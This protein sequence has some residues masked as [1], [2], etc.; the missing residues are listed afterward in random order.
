MDF[1]VVG[2]GVGA[3]LALIGFAL[4]EAST[5]HK[6]ASRRWTPLWRDLGLS[7]MLS[8]V[9][10]WVVTGVALTAGSADDEGTMVLMAAGFIALVGLLGRAAIVART[11]PDVP[12]QTAPPVRQPRR[13]M[14]RPATADLASSH[15]LAVRE[16]L[17]A[18]PTV[19][20]RDLL[21][22]AA[23]AAVAEDEVIVDTS[24]FQRDAVVEASEPEE[25]MPE[26]VSADDEPPAAQAGADATEPAAIE[27]LEQLEQSD[28]ERDAAPEGPDGVDEVVAVQ[29]GPLP[30][31][32]VEPASEAESEIES[33]DLSE[34]RAVEDEADLEPVHADP[35]VD[36]SAATSDEAI[37]PGD[38]DPPEPETLAAEALPEPVP[39]E[40]PEASVQEL[41]P[42]DD[43]REEPAADPEVKEADGASNDGEESPAW[44]TS[45]L[46]ADLADAD[47]G[48]LDE[49]FRSPILADIDRSTEG[50]DDNE[51]GYLEALFGPPRD[52]ESWQPSELDEEV[53]HELNGQRRF[54]RRGRDG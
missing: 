21:D 13:P 18:P 12:V 27:Q 6:A 3:L 44:F 48:S 29:I 8:A 43:S 51:S 20:E 41:E 14:P 4:W 26:P 1:V 17:T 10:L 25:A 39:D 32:A 53:D 19:A 42:E 54:W 9:L 47:L 15:D 45:P 24:I 36:E 11:L 31:R 50:G 23:V 40:L 5:N 28:Q 33:A 35:D 37:E 49:H 38:P 52:D 30:D 16:D 7:L 34:Q 46:L 2:F 22:D